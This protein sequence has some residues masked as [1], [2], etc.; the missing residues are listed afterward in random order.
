M[1]SLTN[2]GLIEVGNIVVK[3]RRR[4][5]EGKPGEREKGGRGREAHKFT[6]KLTHVK[7]H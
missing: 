3:L 1:N 7:T 5:E 6:F 2:T 4:L